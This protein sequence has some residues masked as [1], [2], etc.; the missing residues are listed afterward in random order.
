MTTERVSRGLKRLREGGEEVA[1]KL[2]PLGR[3]A[4]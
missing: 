4:W 1:G 3:A 2:M